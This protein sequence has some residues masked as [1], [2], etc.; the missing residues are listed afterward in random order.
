MVRDIHLKLSDTL[1]QKL[2]RI[3]REKGKKNV[4]ELI[5]HVLI[6]YTLEYTPAPSAPSTLSAPSGSSTTEE[7]GGEVGKRK[8]RKER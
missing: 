2:E 7:R 8:A 1:H 3:A 4:N 5:R 6:D